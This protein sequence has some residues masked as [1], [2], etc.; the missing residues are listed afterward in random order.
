MCGSCFTEFRGD[1]CERQNL[2]YY[3]NHSVSTNELMVI[4][5]SFFLPPK[6]SF[7]CTIQ[8]SK[9]YV[10]AALCTTTCQLFYFPAQMGCLANDLSLR[11]FSFLLKKP[12]LELEAA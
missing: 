2:N 3:L 8:R 11:V 9:F 5:A 4:F 6:Y 10:E 7:T 12:E 1:E